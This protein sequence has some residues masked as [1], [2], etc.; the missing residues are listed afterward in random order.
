METFSGFPDDRYKVLEETRLMLGFKKSEWKC[1]LVALSKTDNGWFQFII[2]DLTIDFKKFADID[3][4]QLKLEMK[5][6]DKA[7]K[8]ARYIYDLKEFTEPKPKKADVK[9]CK[10]E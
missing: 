2:G 3:E 6:N 8:L 5:V 1:L 4:L 7:T 9:P 10:E